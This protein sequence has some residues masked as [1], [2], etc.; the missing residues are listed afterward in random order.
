MKEELA[1]IVYKFKVPIYN[2]DVYFIVSNNFLIT[3]RNKFKIELALSVN[4]DRGIAIKGENGYSYIILIKHKFI[5]HWD[6]ITH[7]S[8]HITNYILSDRGIEC[9]MTNDEAQT[10]LLGYIIEKIQK[11]KYKIDNYG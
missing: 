9:N 2:C 4:Q 10:Y 7:E 1:D 5:N 8:L 3:A 6:T 11:I